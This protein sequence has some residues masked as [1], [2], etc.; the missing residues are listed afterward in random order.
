MKIAILGT[1]GIPNNYGGPETNAEFM[2]PIFLRMGHE[3][4]VYSPDEHPYQE[5]EWNGVRIKHIF[6]RESKLKIFGTFI[7]DFLCLRDALRSDFDIILELGYVPCALF[8]PLRSKRSKSVLITNMDGLEWKRSKWNYLLKKFT[9]LTEVLGARYSDALISDNQAIQTYYREN[10]DLDSYFIP[11]GAKLVYEPE[12][13][14]LGSYG[15][16]QQ[17]YYLLIARMEPE[18]NIEMILD[19]YVLSGSSRPFLLVGKTDT[20]FA[21]YLVEKFSAYTNIRFL[22]GIYDYDVLSALRWHSELY[23]HGHSVGGTNPSLV[24]AMATNTFIVSH[25]NPF[26]RSVLGDQAIY[27]CDSDQVARSIKADHSTYRSDFILANKEKVE[28]IYTWESSAEQ[29][30]K[31]FERE[32]SRK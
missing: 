3:V 9:K 31:A 20:R 21:Q 14:H 8:F 11:Y 6:C 32:I 29:H 5:N 27:F 26:N 16:E 30:I 19:G 17:Q 23:Y 4:T 18:N 7:Y 2:S 24:E 25:D 28:E 15:V 13:D 22:G 12:S 10:Y 1:R